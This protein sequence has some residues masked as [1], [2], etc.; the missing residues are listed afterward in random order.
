MTINFNWSVNSIDS[1]P[2]ENDYLSSSY[3]VNWTCVGTTS[4]SSSNGDVIEY[5]ASESDMT[6]LMYESGSVYVPYGELIDSDVLDNVY[7]TLGVDGVSVVE[8][9]ISESIQ[10]QYAVNR[11]I[12]FDWQVVAL[13]SYPTYDNYENVVFNVHWDCRGTHT[14][15]VSGSSD[16]TYTSNSIGVQELTLQSGSVFVDYDLLTLDTV[17]GWVQYAMGDSEVN[18]IKLN[19]SSSIADKITPRILKLPLPW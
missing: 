11:D 2:I 5:T 1:Y 3:N 7:S 18:N 19:I 6:S 14:V 4:I 9:N 8:A 12:N 15:S 13:E 17:I 16:V 10:Q